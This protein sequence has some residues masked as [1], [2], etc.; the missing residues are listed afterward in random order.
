MNFFVIVLLFFLPFCGTVISGV[1]RLKIVKN[2]RKREVESCF[3]RI[4][5]AYCK[6]EGKYREY[7]K[8]QEELNEN[9]KK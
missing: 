7:Y 1:E 5:A 3:E 9:K 2:K 8:Q 4:K 6:T